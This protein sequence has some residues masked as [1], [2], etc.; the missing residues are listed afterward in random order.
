MPNAT[1][2]GMIGRD[3][4]YP[5]NGTY[6]QTADIDGSQLNQ[7][8]GNKNES[9]TGEYD[10]QC[11][12]ISDLSDCFVDTLQGSIRN[13]HFTGANIISQKTTGLAACVV[14]VNGTVS[15][16]WAGNVH[17]F[18]WGKFAHAGIGGGGG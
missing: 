16:I 9:F 13:L 11:R 1:I 17:I 6:R 7:S 3:P 15:D 14:Y 8:I 12:T 2:L 4:D 18:T 10:G 5:L